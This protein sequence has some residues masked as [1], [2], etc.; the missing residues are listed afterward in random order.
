MESEY[1]EG[2]DQAEKN[3]QIQFLDPKSKPYGP[4]DFHTHLPEKGQL[5]ESNTR[6]L[7]RGAQIIFEE[8]LR[9]SDGETIHA[10]EVGPGAGN[11]ILQMRKLAEFEN[12]N[13]ELNAFSLTPINPYIG[14]KKSVPQLCSETKGLVR[15]FISEEEG[16][17]VE[18]NDVLE[19]EQKIRDKVLEV[20][21][22]QRP[23]VD[24]QYI[25]DFPQ[26]FKKESEIWG[27][28]D[29]AYMNRSIFNS[30][31]PPI[32]ETLKLLNENGIVF[33]APKWKEWRV[34]EWKSIL[35]DENCTICLSEN[36]AEGLEDFALIVKNGSKLGQKM[37]R[38][39]NKLGR[40]NGVEASI[41]LEILEKICGE[42]K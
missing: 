8:M 29:F 38:E 6:P 32:E 30:E 36:N 18:L 25:G 10:N 31:T 27:K 14:L 21:T 9:L 2:I 15:K 20:R 22:T 7:E 28:Y 12:A 11:A 41:N 13:V 26:D 39:L 33:I 16:Y 34:E 17:E 42:T 35:A 1:L 5:L 4:S 40:V 3:G 23:F 24:H 37:L 19:L